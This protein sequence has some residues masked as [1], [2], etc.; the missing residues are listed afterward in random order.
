MLLVEKEKRRMASWL[1]VFF[2]IV[3][4]EYKSAMCK[5]EKAS[6]V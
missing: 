4:G 3:V 6:R 5:M 1:F 2:V